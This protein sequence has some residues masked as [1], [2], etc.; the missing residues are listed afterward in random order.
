MA[1]LPARSSATASRTNRAGL[2]T[3]VSLSTMS[4]RV[5][6]RAI[7]PPTAADSPRVND[8][9]IS[10]SAQSLMST[11]TTLVVSPEAKVSVPPVGTKSRLQTVPGLALA[12]AVSKWTDTWLVPGADR[13]TTRST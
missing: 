13:L 10:G 1:T 8:S 9:R 6:A 7:V 5:L 3:T 4:I 2:A 12:E 11:R